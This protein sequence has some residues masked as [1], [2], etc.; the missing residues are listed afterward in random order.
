MIDPQKTFKRAHTVKVINI[1]G[2]AGLCAGS[3]NPDN[4]AP[5]D[6]PDGSIYLRTN[7]R[8]YRRI[9]GKWRTSGSM[10]D[11]IGGLL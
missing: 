7:G 6:M 2:K 3:G 8:Q 9:N 5:P 4:D 11:L 10:V 1:D